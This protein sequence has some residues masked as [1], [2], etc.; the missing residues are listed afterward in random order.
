MTSSTT[1][2][3]RPRPGLSSRIRYTERSP[4]PENISLA[5]GPVGS[6]RRHCVSYAIPFQQVGLTNTVE[7][8]SLLLVHVQVHEWRYTR[9]YISGRG[10]RPS[11]SSANLASVGLQWHRYPRSNGSKNG[12]LSRNVLGCVREPP[13]SLW[14]KLVASRHPGEGRPKKNRN[15]RRYHNGFRVSDSTRTSKTL[16]F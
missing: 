10:H 5:S 2:R 4:A 11:V 1:R 16:T 12:S 3:V 9:V 7:I 14:P 8:R 13:T 15:K 6:P